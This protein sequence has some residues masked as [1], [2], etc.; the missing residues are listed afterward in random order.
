MPALLLLP[1]LAL[2]AAQAEAPA[3]IRV[4][5]FN[6]S[7]NRAHAGDLIRDLAAPND[8]QA[9]NVAEVLQRIRP[10]IVLLNEF[11]Y[12]PDHRAL[13][14]FRKNYLAISQKDAPPLEYPHAYTGPV[15]T[16]V[17]SGA[18]LDG[19]G[20]IEFTPGTRTYGN[21]AKGF[22]QFP[23]QYGMVVLSRFP[24]DA[25]GVRAF[26]ALLWKDMPD[27][28]LPQKADGSSFY[29][30]DALARLPL[31][32]K[33]HWDVPVRVGSR[34]LHILASHPTPPAFDGPEDRNGRRNHDEIRLWADYLT[35]GDK[36]RYLGSSLDADASF[37]IVGDLNADPNDGGTVAGAISQ[38]LDHP[39]V[40]SQVVPTSEGAQS[41]AREQK[42]AND[43][44]RT[45]AEQDTADFAD[46]AVG[47]LR[48]DYVLPSRDLIVKSA[49]VF[50]PPPSDPL[51]RLAETGSPPPT[52]DHHLVYLDLAFPDRP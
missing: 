24:I 3:T 48:A 39:R 41:A 35:G 14:L 9:R 30:A 10:D 21:D 37:V 2:A 40:A 47:N 18:D 11:D 15:N 31:S 27:A 51:A 5:T 1:V 12:D 13:D 45:P 19:D 46:A 17:P 32:S 6:V 22:G 16:G 34:T 4:A 49:G 26:G 50:W 7:L 36:A 43:A 42:G 33:N 28:L 8:A 20:K 29:S 25:A 44:H 23:G 52:S 38:L